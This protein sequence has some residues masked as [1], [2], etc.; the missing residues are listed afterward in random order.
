MSSFFRYLGHRTEDM[1][2]DCAVNLTDNF[3]LSGSISG[4]LWCWDLIT[5]KV[6]NK[7]CHTSGKVLNSLAVHP[8][9]NVVLTASVNTIKIWAKPDDVKIDPIVA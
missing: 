3:I 7:L 9:K 4:E 6:T 8:T 5:A 1:T 2:I